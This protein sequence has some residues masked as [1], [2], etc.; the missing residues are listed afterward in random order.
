[1]KKRAVVWLLAVSI[2]GI[3]CLLFFDSSIVDYMSSI[4]NVYLDALF[5]V[6]ES[7]WAIILIVIAVLAMLAI[8][9]K[10]KSIGVFILTLV[11]STIASFALKFIIM[12]PRPLGLIELLPIVN[13]V[14]YSFPSSH[15][16][17][18]FSMLPVISKEFPKLKYLF[19]ALACLIVISR[20][21]FNVHYASDIILGAVIGYL[22]GYFALRLTE[23]K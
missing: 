14:D 9:H 17:F 15:A 6:L 18:I 21:Y 7:Y 22:V 8:N 20:I 5:S 19:M 13:W 3:L 4:Q 23:R 16:V 11:S 10:N 1:M 12:R 2:I